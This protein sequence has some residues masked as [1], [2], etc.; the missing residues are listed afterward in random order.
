MSSSVPGAVVGFYNALVASVPSPTLI[1][2]GEPRHDLEAAEH[3]SVAYAGEGGGEVIDTTSD[4][5]SLG[6]HRQEERYEVVNALVV[7]AGDDSEEALQTAFL[8]AYEV[9][10]AIGTAVADD[11]TLDGAVRE[12]RIGTHGTAVE[13]TGRGV[14]V[15]VTFRLSCAS[16]ITY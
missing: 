1:H 15:T 2:F 5:A 9:F 16:R 8:R 6:A 14:S 13:Q 10:D 7:W 4:W 11:I 3:V 12:S